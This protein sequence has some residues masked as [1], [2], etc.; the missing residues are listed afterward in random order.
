MLMTRVSSIGSFAR[1]PAECASAQTVRLAGVDAEVLL[2]GGTSFTTYARALDAARVFPGSRLSALAVIG[3]GNRAASGPRIGI[4]AS[5]PA[6]LHGALGV[7]TLI[8]EVRAMGAVPVLVPPCADMTVTDREAAMRQMIAA[9]DGLIGPGGADVDPSIYGERLTHAEDTNP[10]RDRFEADF[11]LRALKSDIFML[12]IC[13]SHQLWNAAA[14]GDLVQDLKK[15]GVNALSQRQTE[16]GLPKDRPFVLHD[17]VGRVMF[18][19]R[20]EL[21]PLSSIIGAQTLL[22]NSFH[23]QAV[24][25]PGRGFRPIGTV[26]DDKTGQRV[27]E[28]TEGKNALT[29]QWH[30]E[31][32]PADAVERRI[33]ETVGRRA[34]IV[35]MMKGL[36][37]AKDS[38]ERALRAEMQRSGIDFDRSDYAFARAML[39]GR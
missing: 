35:H 38:S 39:A 23:H 1:P 25:T 24:R 14:G 13:R 37:G 26:L 11:A 17:A 21:A 15:D 12:G 2:P 33:L 20:V 32:M 22:T 3:P 36:R 16:F 10:T 6:A 31:L 9:L 34:H 29:V 27:I 30:P 8:R 18:E 4:M 7:G 19:H 5:E 28:A